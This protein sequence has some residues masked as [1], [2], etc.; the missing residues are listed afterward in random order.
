MLFFG[1]SCLQ[2]NVSINKGL[3][4]FTYKPLRFKTTL[5]VTIVQFIRTKMLQLIIALK[6][7]K[8]QDSETR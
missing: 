8:L 5:K 6:L 3:K 2:I 7:N 4:I 1:Y